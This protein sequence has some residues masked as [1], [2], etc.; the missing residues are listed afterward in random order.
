MTLLITAITFNYCLEPQPVTTKRFVY[1]PE[2]GVT[3]DSLNDPGKEFNEVFRQ[4]VKADN[5]AMGTVR[6]FWKG[7]G[8]PV[9]LALPLRGIEPNMLCIGDLVEHIV[10]MM[11]VLDAFKGAAAANNPMFT[12]AK[13]I[14]RLDK[15]LSGI[16]A[17]KNPTLTA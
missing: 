8:S 14:G 2:D 17:G 5:L 1:D 11:L 7:C 4:L 12:L 16:A 15:A 13:Q 9:T 3:S 6:V 10:R